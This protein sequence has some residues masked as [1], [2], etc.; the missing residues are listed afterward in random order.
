MCHAIY[1]PICTTDG[2]ITSFNNFV[3]VCSHAFLVPETGGW[4]LGRS[5]EARRA[6]TDRAGQKRRIAYWV[7]HLG[8]DISLLFMQF[9]TTLWAESL[10]RIIQCFLCSF[11]LSLHVFQIRGWSEITQKWTRVPVSDR[12]ALFF[13]GVRSI[14]V[15]GEAYCYLWLIKRYSLH[16]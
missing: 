4:G 13:S 1:L 2:V 11:V 12:P 8:Q 7:S 15:F 16:F 3:G 9:H 6:H 10:N 14:L 5:D